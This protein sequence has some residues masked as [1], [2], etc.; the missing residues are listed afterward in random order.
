MKKNIF[1]LLLAVVVAFAGIA[2]IIN[3]LNADKVE[4]NNTEASTTMPQPDTTTETAAPIP[5]APKTTA[6]ETTAAEQTEESVSTEADTAAAPVD[7]IDKICLDQSYVG[8]WDAT[9]SNTEVG[10]YEITPDSIKFGLCVVHTL[11]FRATAVLKDGEFV[12]GD[13]ISPDFR[14][15]AMLKGRLEFKDN[16]IIVYIEDYGKINYKWMTRAGYVI[17]TRKAYDFSD[18]I[19]RATLDMFPKG[20]S[21]F[22]ESDW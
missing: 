15:P 20:T 12:F 7:E 22:D 2:V 3:A 5:E 6:P 10:I 1:T 13:G 19:L 4:D 11:S 16:S 21:T 14:G 18:E 8:K 17:E 9:N